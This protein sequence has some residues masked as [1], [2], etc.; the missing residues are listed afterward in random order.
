[1]RQAQSAR[2]AASSSLAPSFP[3]TRARAGVW[4]TWRYIC[5][6]CMQVVHR[7]LPCVYVIHA[8][9][10]QLV[11][12]RLPLLCLPLIDFWVYARVLEVAQ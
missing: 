8:A 9:Y 12:G 11:H 4:C 7:R 1:M 2:L 6:L 5:S 10:L 3:L